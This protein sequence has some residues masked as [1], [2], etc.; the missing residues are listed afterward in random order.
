MIEKIGLTADEVAQ[1]E[2]AEKNMYLPYDKETGINPQD[3]SFMQKEVWDFE[4]TPKDHY[5]LLLHYHPLYIYRYQVCKQADTVLAHFI[6]EDAQD[7]ET[8]RKSFEYYEKVTTHD[9]SL[10]TCIYSIVASKLGEEEKAYAY[11]GDS[12]KLDLFNLHHNTKDGIHTANM[13][14]NYMAIVYGFGRSET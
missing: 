9:S 2:K 12:A 13:G 7:I 10:S 14:G 4:N 5:P 11:F 1:M 6:Y 3:D 8:I